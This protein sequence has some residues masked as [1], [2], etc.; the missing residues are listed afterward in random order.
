[1]HRRTVARRTILLL[2]FEALIFFVVSIVRTGLL[3]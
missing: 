1:L 2:M 3:R